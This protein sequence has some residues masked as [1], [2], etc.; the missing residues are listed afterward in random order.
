MAT[1]GK[2]DLSKQISRIEADLMRKVNTATIRA[3]NV[4]AT[5]SRKV[6]V[7]DVN[8][9]TGIQKGTIRRRV[10]INKAKPGKLEASLHISARRITLPGPRTINQAKKR[11]GISFIGEG[12]QRKKITSHIE[13]KGTGSKPFIITGKNSG[14]K[15][16]VYVLPGYV[17]NKSASTRKVQAMYTSS[18]AHMM[19]KDWR[20]SVRDY[21]IKELREEFEKQF[22]KVK[23]G[24]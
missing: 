15:V 19:R 11:A 17:K 20:E 8:N 10:L 4:V 18:L 5:R 2:I 1:F 6:L 3:L 14:K 16:P 12:K 24:F 9:D 7:D 21:A 13:N 23:K 22:K